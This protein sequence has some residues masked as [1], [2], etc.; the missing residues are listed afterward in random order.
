MSSNQPSAL[1]REKI[2]LGNSHLS[3]AGKI[4]SQESSAQRVNTNDLGARADVTQITSISTGV[5]ADGRNGVIT[6]VASTLAADA[7]ATLVLTNKYLSTGSL[8]ILSIEYDGST[9]SKP[10]AMVGALADGSCNIVL[11][12]VG[13]AALDAVVNVHYLIL[14]GAPD[15]TP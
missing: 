1:R 14:G 15:I 2:S 4:Q 3:L 7:E 13:T 10:S 6:T 5:T 12:N 9:V 8:V 11:S